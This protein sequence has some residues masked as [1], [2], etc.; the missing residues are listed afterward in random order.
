MV[1]KP[2]RRAARRAV[3]AAS[4]PIGVSAL[5]LAPFGSLVYPQV[6]LARILIAAYNGTPSVGV[7]RVRPVK[8][9]KEIRPES[10]ASRQA[11][12]WNRADNFWRLSTSRRFYLTYDIC[13]QIVSFYPCVPLE[14]RKPYCKGKQKI[15]KYK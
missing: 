13:L 10:I 11:P 8:R 1:V 6:P 15:Y 12:K 3:S 14:H 5:H 9:I 4:F 2:Y 7:R